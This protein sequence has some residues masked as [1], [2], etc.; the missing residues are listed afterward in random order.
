MSHG[1]VMDHKAPMGITAGELLERTARRAEALAKALA[2]FYAH[3]HGG[4]RP[5]E[6]SYTLAHESAVKNGWS[7]GGD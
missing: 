5:S 1:P 6:E 7:L 3:E 2:D 4:P